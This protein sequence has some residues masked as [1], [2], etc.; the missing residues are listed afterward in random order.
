MP[1][2]AHILQRHYYKINRYPHAGKFNIPVTDILNY[3]RQAH[4]IL[5]VPID[6]NN[7][8][9]ILTTTAPIGHDKHGNE[10][11]II[12]ILTDAG[13]KIVTAFPGSNV[14]A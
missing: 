5:P 8:Q 4:D 1:V 2:L 9:R 13:G 11:N 10:T 12:T 14:E 7:W 6:G 3:I